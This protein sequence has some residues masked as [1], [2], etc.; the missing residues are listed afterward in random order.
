M[1]D[2]AQSDEE[3]ASYVTLMAGSDNNVI[4]MAKICADMGELRKS[5]DLYRGIV[6]RLV[7]DVEILKMSHRA[8]QETIFK[9]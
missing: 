2:L 3:R 8:R 7:P 1:F 4:D 5:L 6:E 9:R